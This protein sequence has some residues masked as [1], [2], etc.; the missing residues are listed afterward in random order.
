MTIVSREP[1][2]KNS[3]APRE[4]PAKLSAPLFMSSAVPLEL[5]V[6]PSRS[7]DQFKTPNSETSNSSAG[8]NFSS[9]HKSF[10]EIRSFPKNQKTI[11]T[12]KSRN[13][14]I[15]IFKIL[16]ESPLMEEKRL[17][18]IEKIETIRKIES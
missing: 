14:K 12:T 8:S 10:E 3:I 5:F 1:F 11:P 13:L 18:A 7:S 9:L 15:K 6:V 2:I 16:T 4:T 17:Q